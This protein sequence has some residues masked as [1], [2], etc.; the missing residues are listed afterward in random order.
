MLFLG[1]RRELVA[2]T[3]TEAV[4]EGVE[5]DIMS[6]VLGD[7]ISQVGRLKSPSCCG[8]ILRPR[9]VLRTAGSRRRLF[10]K[11]EV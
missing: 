9:M 4:G 2:L 5:V 1:G 6:S 7:C 3:L 11:S 8:R 10:L